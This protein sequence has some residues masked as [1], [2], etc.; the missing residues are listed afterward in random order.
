MFA[1]TAI[2]YRAIKNPERSDEGLETLGKLFVLT[3]LL[4]AAVKYGYRACSEQSIGQS[5]MAVAYAAAF[6]ASLRWLRQNLGILARIR[7]LGPAR[8]ELPQT[9]PAI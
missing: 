8:S 4:I 1:L 7:S 5:A 6:I 9:A 2:A 3:I